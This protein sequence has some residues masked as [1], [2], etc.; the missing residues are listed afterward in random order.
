VTGQ[1]TMGTN[2]RFP[3]NTRKHFCVEQVV[4]KPERLW[5]FLPGNLHKPLGHM[6][7]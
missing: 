2:R 3:L 5:S 4:E 1:E 7:R 6:L